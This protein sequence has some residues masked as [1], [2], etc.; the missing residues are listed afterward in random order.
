[1]RRSWLVPLIAGI[2]SV[3]AGLIVLS[4]PWTVAQL[5]VFA[6]FIF[7]FRGVAIG[8]NAAEGRAPTW[9][10]VLAG[11]AGVIAG[12]WLLAWPG[13]SLLVLAIFIGAWLTVSGVFNAVGAVVARREIRHWGLVLAIGIIEVLLG[14]WA[15]RRPAFSLGLAITVLGFWAIITGALYIAVALE[16]RSLVRS[17]SETALP[18]SAHRSG[19]AS[20]SD[21][22]VFLLQRLH[23]AGLLADPDLAL[24][25]AA[26]ADVPA[27]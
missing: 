11:V 26:V 27:R 21:S 8:L 4:T 13:P 19:A 22:P 12:F 9:L 14:M 20:R 1:M 7:I 17:V 15:M 5:A 10:G 18:Y 16:L 3:A 2:V 23:Q 24:L 25:L 6:A